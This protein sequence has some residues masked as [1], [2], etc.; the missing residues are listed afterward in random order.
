MCVRLCVC[1]CVCHR[2]GKQK[3]KSVDLGLWDPSSQP[4]NTLPPDWPFPPSTE[5]WVCTSTSGAAVLTNEQREAPYRAVSQRL[6][7]VAWPRTDVPR[8]RVETE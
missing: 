2:K 7:Q 4:P 8:C 5:V 1:V 3:V 6:A